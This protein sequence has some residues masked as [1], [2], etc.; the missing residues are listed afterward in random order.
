MINIKK[1][2]Y[3]LVTLIIITIFTIISLNKI[4]PVKIHADY[5]SDDEI[6]LIMA[7]VK[8]S[9]VFAEINTDVALLEQPDKNANPVSFIDKQ[10]KVEILKDR[11]MEWY[12][13]KDIKN[14]LCGWVTSTYLDI[15]K[16]PETN[17]N[18]MT[19]K[20]LEGYVNI[21]SFESKTPFLI[22]TDIDRQLTYIFK[23]KAKNWQL[24]KTF[25]CATGK[26]VSPTTRGIF[27]LKTR[28]KWFYSGRL[29]SGA[30]YWVR[31][32]DSY[33]F[34]SVAMDQNKKIVDNVLG[35]RRSSGCIRMSVENAK[36]IYEKVPDKTTVFVH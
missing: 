6:K 1:V 25:E 30:K 17:K 11:T 23:G 19:K 31:F 32:N 4:I 18:E 8:P 28:D 5:Y 12:L 13:V 20:Q 9:Y 26:N 15:P 21:M 10:S 35:E 34:H 24:I 27:T 36:Y 3:T 29:N 14:D 33:L 7:L 2:K 16:D 22:W